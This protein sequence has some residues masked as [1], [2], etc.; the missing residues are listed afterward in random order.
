[1]FLKPLRKK[2]VASLG[3]RFTYW[4]IKALGW[5]VRLKVIHPEIPRSLWERGIPFIMTFWHGRL[6]MMAHGYKGKMLS[7]LISSHRDGQIMGKAGQWFGHHPIVGSTTRKGFSGFKNMIKAIQNGSDVVIAPDGPKGPHQKAQMGVVELSRLTGKPMV[8]VSFSASKKILLNTWDRFLLPCP[9][10]RGVF[11]W[12]DP[13]YIDP[14][15]NRNHLEERRQLLE[16]RL[17]ELTDLADHF[18]DPHV[19]GRSLRKNS[20]FES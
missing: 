4:A 5:T 9:F 15:G 19:S 16:N 8:P 10:S 17:N 18:F 3:P 13:I 1:M 20:D 2:I 14:D 7:F 6:L 11:I 12:G